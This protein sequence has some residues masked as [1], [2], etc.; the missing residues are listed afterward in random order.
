MKHFLDWCVLEVFLVYIFIW[1]IDYFHQSVTL[2]LVLSC[3]KIV[4]DFCKV[5]FALAMQKKNLNSRRLIVLP[6]WDKFGSYSISLWISMQYLLNIYQL[7]KH[8]TQWDTI[9]R[10]VSIIQRNQTVTVFSGNQWMME[11]SL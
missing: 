11:D 10:S 1:Q 8:Y 7:T 2:F 4:F 9:L 6:P 3:R 5:K